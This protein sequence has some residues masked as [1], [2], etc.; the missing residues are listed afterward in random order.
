MKKNSFFIF[1]SL[2]STVFILFLYALFLPQ[3]N[4]DI[5]LEIK[6]K[7][8]GHNFEHL[9]N[10]N[11]LLYAKV[12]NLKSYVLTLTNNTESKGSNQLQDLELRSS[13]VLLRSPASVEEVALDEVL[14]KNLQN[15]IKSDKYVDCI[16]LC[17]SFL[18]K[19]PVSLRQIETH[20]FLV[21]SYFQ[22]NDYKKS[23]EMTE[24][25]MQLF[26][27]H[28]LTGFALLR[29]GQVSQMQSRQ[30]EAVEI[31]ETIQLNYKNQYL[32]DQAKNLSEK[33]IKR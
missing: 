20:Y 2:L 18:Q 33:Y 25:M 15:L 3:I 8:L 16:V 32:K 24:K 1:A 17:E 9:N 13:Q 23:I 28:E 14:F 5:D 11:K 12:E 7:N 30:D 4:R 29:M 26:P 22:L 31:F 6:Y 27:E 19:Y 10:E 21:E